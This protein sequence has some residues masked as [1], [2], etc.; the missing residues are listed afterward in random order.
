MS[1]DSFIREVD[2]E[3][4]QDRV[5]AFWQQYGLWIIAGA[6]AIVLATAGAVLYQ[7]WV[8]SRANASGDAFLQALGLAERGQAGEAEAALQQLEADG[9]GAYPVLARLRLATL[10]AGQG[11]ID[12]AIAGFDS[13]AADSGVPEVIRDLARLRAAYLLVDHG[14]REDVAARVEPLTGDAH[15]LRHSARE[16]L[17]LAA[18]RAGDRDNAAALF[19]QIVN[20]AE[21][22]LNLRERAGM[23]AELVRGTGASG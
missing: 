10:K 3:L 23:M 13:V 11:E 4:R 5:K 17:G 19:Q 18:F 1:D 15:P 21:A 9:F 8:Q 16:A 6:V 12:A 22:P 14:S 20:D 7:N 2:E